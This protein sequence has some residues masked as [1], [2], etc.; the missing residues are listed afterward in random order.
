MAPSFEAY[1]NQ[2]QHFSLTR[3]ATSPPL[4]TTVT[5]L[6][7]PLSTSRVQPTHTRVPHHTYCIASPPTNSLRNKHPETLATNNIHSS[8]IHTVVNNLKLH[9]RHHP[10]SNPTTTDKMYFSSPTANITPAMTSVHM[11]RSDSRDSTS[12]TSNGF[13]YA[14]TTAYTA[15]LSASPSS[16]W[17]TAHPLVRSDSNTSTTPSQTSYTSSPRT[18]I[19][20]R[21]DSSNS[22]WLP[23]LY[24]SCQ[25][26]FGGEPN[27]YLSDDD[28]LCPSD[29]LSLPVESIP[30]LS[31]KK[32]L[33]TEEQIALLRELQEKEASHQ[34]QGSDSCRDETQGRSLCEPR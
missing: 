17:M 2:S 30:S 8:T 34:Q 29:E 16:S 28:L 31:P 4:I 6:S 1:K 13:S 20:M 5:T 15:L 7:H 25:S 3:A 32:E 14:P 12:T 33:T 9:H 19:A 23:S 26:S 21:R 27:S 22:S 24:R 11:S 10:T 18:S